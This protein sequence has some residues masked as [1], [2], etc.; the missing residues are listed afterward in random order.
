MGGWLNGGVLYQREAGGVTTVNRW[1]PLTQQ[2]ETLKPHGANALSANGQYWAGWLAGYGMFTESLLKPAGGAPVV[3]PDGSI[4]YAP[5]YAH[6]AVINVLERDGSEWRLSA[7]GAY[8]IQLFGSRVVLWRE[9]FTV[10]TLGL[11]RPVTLDPSQGIWGPRACAVNGELWIAYY[12]GAIGGLVLHPFASTEGY[13]VVSGEAFNADIMA[14]DGFV[15]VTWATH[16]GEQP[17]EAKV[18]TVSLSEPR[19][20]LATPRLPPIVVPVPPIVVP[21]EPTPVPDSKYLTTLKTLRAKYPER[22]LTP[23]QLGELLNAF[24]WTYRSEGAGLYPKDSGSVAV[25]PRTGRKISSDVFLIR[26]NG[27]LMWRDVLGDAEG[28]AVP[29][30]PEGQIAGP[31]YLE[32][33]Q[34]LDEPV[35]VPDP[36][37]TPVPTPNDPAVLQLLTKM[38]EVQMWQFNRTKE[39]A[40]SLKAIQKDIEGLRKELPAAI[41]KLVLL[42]KK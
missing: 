24:A 3:G 8:D 7:G 30:W 15:W 35:P 1:D 37:P 4:A 29:N 34:P 25:Q 26:E 13:L 31:G 38:A 5:D 21:T 17:G 28:E 20:Q 12:S 33:V 11:P 40:I 6:S 2:S 42:G 36:D 14:G 41:A 39:C 23:E 19:E 27:V 9:G 16:E 22:N 32:P 18:R 10:R